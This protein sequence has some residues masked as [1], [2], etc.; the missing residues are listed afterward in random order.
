[1]QQLINGCAAFYFDTWMSM[2]GGKDDEAD[3]N[4]LET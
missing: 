3:T 4:W 1:M 2:F